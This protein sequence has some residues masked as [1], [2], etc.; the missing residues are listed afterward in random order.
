[1][2]HNFGMSKTAILPQVRV[3]PELRAQAE[4]ALLPGEKLSDLVET[5]VRRVLEHRALQQTFEEHSRASLE[6]FRATGEVHSTA[7]VLGELRRRTQARREELV[8]QG[9]T[10]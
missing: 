1:V 2:K 10:T 9:K 3:D 6:H 4:A 5:A 8:R 7:D